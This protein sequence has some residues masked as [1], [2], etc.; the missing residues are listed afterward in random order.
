[1][2]KNRIFR[3]SISGRFDNEDGSGTF[4]IR[5]Y[6]GGIGAVVVTWNDTPGSSSL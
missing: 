6:V 3:S 1:M 4:K 5:I 2:V